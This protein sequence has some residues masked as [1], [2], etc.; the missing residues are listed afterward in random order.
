[1]KGETLTRELI[2]S[3]LR[4]SNQD[5]VQATQE[6]VRGLVSLAVESLSTQIPYVNFNN[7]IFEP[8]NEA[9]SGGFSDGL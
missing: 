3:I 4:V 2:E 8:V 7:V 1:M 6:K 5:Y 9:L